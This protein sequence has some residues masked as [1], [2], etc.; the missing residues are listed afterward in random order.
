MQ[1]GVLAYHAQAWTDLGATPWVAKTIR[2]G[3]RLRW[4][5]GPPPK[6]R[7]TGVW[8]SQDTEKAMN[9]Q[10]SRGL[11][12]LSNPED[13]VQFVSRAFAIHPQIKWETTTGRGSFKALH[14]P[15]CTPLQDER[16]KRCS[17]CNG[18]EHLGCDSGSK[19]CIWTVSPARVGS[20]MASSGSERQGLPSAGTHSGN[21]C[22]S[23]HIYQAGANSLA[24]NTKAGSH[25]NRLSRRFVSPI[26]EE[27][28]QGSSTPPGSIHCYIPK[29]WI[30]CESRKE[31]A[32]SSTKIFFLG[33]GIQH[34]DNGSRVAGRQTN[35]SPRSTPK[36]I[37]TQGDYTQ[38]GSAHG[39]CAKS[40]SS[41]S[42]PI[43]A[44]VNIQ[45]AEGTC[46]I[47]KQQR[48]GQYICPSTCGIGRAESSPSPCR[49]TG[50]DLGTIT[51]A[52]KQ[53]KTSAG[54]RSTSTI[55]SKPRAS[56]PARH[57]QPTEWVH[58]STAQNSQSPFD[59]AQI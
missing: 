22:S 10:V 36:V 28:L 5:D 49:E 23:L 56:P 55:H 31:H 7:A 13:K 46:P 50:T 45:C 16:G 12:R 30:H 52:H 47:G 19:R 57:G 41:S 26:S 17:D 18:T 11:W 14:I 37:K 3:I 24:S 20:K 25:N 58:R 8:S 15:E 54:T 32:A 42:V 44:P 4:K 35:G 2:E 27:V 38:T 33:T 43:S 6:R 21:Q 51:F 39:W 40:S 59:L 48:M 9:D 53:K 1:G 29:A 34:A